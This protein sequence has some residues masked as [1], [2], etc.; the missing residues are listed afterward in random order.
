MSPKG[1]PNTLQYKK[2]VQAASNAL[3]GEVDM[4][5]PELP[6]VPDLTVQTSAGSVCNQVSLATIAKAH[7]NDSVLGLFIIRRTNQRAQPFQKVGAKWYKSICY[8]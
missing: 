8:S 1:H 6:E 3:E 5:V 4:N 2:E 7:T